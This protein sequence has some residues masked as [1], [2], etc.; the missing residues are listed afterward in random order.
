MRLLPLI[1]AVPVVLAFG[2]AEALWTNRRAAAD[3][4]AAAAERLGGL[5]LSVGDWQGQALELD[6]RQISKAGISG[7]LMRQ[8]VHRPTGNAV[9]VLLLCGRP[10]PIAV[11]PPDVCY[12]GAGFATVAPP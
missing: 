5:P 4:S 12:G 10:G 7:Y 6:P 9:T 2:T 8:Y 3:T 1:S 11:H